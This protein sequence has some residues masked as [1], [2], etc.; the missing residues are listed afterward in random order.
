VT[1]RGNYSKNQWKTL[2]TEGTILKKK[3]WTIRHSTEKKETTLS[4]STVL[5]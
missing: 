2:K 3:Q 5:D 4:V 1:Q